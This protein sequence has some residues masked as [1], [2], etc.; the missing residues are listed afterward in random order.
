MEQYQVSICLDEAKSL[1]EAGDKDQ[2]INILK[3]AVD[4]YPKNNALNKTYNS[5]SRLDIS[6]IYKGKITDPSGKDTNSIAVEIILNHKDKN[7]SGTVI[8]YDKGEALNT[9]EI[10]SGIVDDSIINFLAKDSLGFVILKFD[11][12]QV[13]NALEGEVTLSSFGTVKVHLSAKKT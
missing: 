8:L 2:A 4:K 11:G 12:K 9:L 6:G 13:D 7:L 3:T 10:K 1:W 5:Y